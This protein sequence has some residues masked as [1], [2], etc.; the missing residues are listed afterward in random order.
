MLTTGIALVL[1][2]LVLVG[3]ESYSF[4]HTRIE[5][6]NGGGRHCRSEQFGRDRFS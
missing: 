1:A 3:V 6:L 4:Y 2:G 5:T